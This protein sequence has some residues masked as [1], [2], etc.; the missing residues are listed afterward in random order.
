MSDIKCW[1]CGRDRKHLFK[2]LKHVSRA[3]KEPIK[4]YA[5]TGKGEPNHTVWVCEVCRSL[6]DIN[7]TNANQESVRNKNGT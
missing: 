7:Q 3:S 1:V 2:D 4:I 5:T 6:L